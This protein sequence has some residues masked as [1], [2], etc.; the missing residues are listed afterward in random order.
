[1]NLP[2]HQHRVSRRFSAAAA[3]YDKVSVVQQEVA[4]QVLDLTPPAFTPGRLLDAGCGTGRLLT[5]ARARWPQAEMVGLDVAPGMI[6]QAQERF[7]RDPACSFA[8]GDAARYRSDAP[9]DLLL[10]SSALQWLHPLDQGLAHLFANLRPGGL[11]AAGLMTRYTLHELR[12]AR[13]AVA[14]HKR[15][16]AHLPDLDAVQAAVHGLPNGHLLQIREQAWTNTYPD[17]RAMLQTLHVMGVTGGDISHGRIPLNRH[18]LEE[19]IAYYDAH[20]GAPGGGVVATFCVTFILL[21][22]T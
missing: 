13:E 16:A 10:S 6:E 7:A 12:S 17:A 9:F 14:P 3:S 21:E 19:L 8:T 4:Q 22:H 20:H 15:S 2:S 5:L 1:M 11:L 18:E